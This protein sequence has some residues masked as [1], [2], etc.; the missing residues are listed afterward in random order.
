VIS[1]IRAFASIELIGQILALRGAVWWFLTF[2]SAG[3]STERA[4]DRISRL[5]G[6][7]PAERWSC[8]IN[9]PWCDRKDPSSEP[10]CMGMPLPNRHD[11]YGRARHRVDR[12]VAERI[13]SDF[14]TIVAQE[15]DVRGK[16]PVLATR[17]LIVL[18]NKKK[19]HHPHPTTLHSISVRPLR[20]AITARNPSC[21]QLGTSNG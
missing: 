10:A 18:M 16:A 3:T 9:I 12:A 11:C 17:L 20:D 14:V 6:S 21:T 19:L 13:D 5:I 1:N 8:P 4:A 2:F 15:C 7:S